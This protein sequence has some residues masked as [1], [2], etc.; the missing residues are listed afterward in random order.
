MPGSSMQQL[1]LPDVPCL[2]WCM[3]MLSTS[4]KMTFLARPE[5]VRIVTLQRP[6]QNADASMSMAT[7]WQAIFTLEMQSLCFLGKKTKLFKALR[8]QTQPVTGAVA[9]QFSVGKH[10]GGHQW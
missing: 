8:P 7:A 2:T 10:V 6:G 4:A 5:A 3:N 1:A 9:L